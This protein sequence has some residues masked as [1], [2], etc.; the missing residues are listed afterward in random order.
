MAK[1]AKN[2]TKTATKTKTGA[3][4]TTSTGPKPNN[5]HRKMYGLD[6]KPGD[7]PEF[8]KV[9]NQAPG[10]LNVFWLEPTVYT[11]PEKDVVLIHVLPNTLCFRAA[12]DDQN[13]LDL[14]RTCEFFVAGTEDLTFKSDGTPNPD[15]KTQRLQS[16]VEIDDKPATI[17]L[18]LDPNVAGKV[19][20]R[21]DFDPDENGNGGGGGWGG[22]HT[23]VNP[24]P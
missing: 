21:V 11:G 3:N 10:A 1:K 16:K 14:W 12:F 22:G 24:P 17:T 2:K 19:H 20:V 5:W 8:K 13:M 7:P 23:F 15:E 6:A 18:C 4:I 9:V